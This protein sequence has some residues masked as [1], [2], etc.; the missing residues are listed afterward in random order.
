MRMP[1][2]KIVLFLGSGRSS[3][4]V[5]HALTS[6]FPIATTVVEAPIPPGEFLRR[7]VKR[8][9]VTTVAG[10]I[11]F[12]AAIVPWLE[13]LSAK[14]VRSILAANGLRDD[15]VGE[16][17]TRVRNVNEPEVVQLLR[18]IRPSV[19]VVNGTRI[20]RK[21]V[22]EATDAV[23]FNLH[24]GITPLYRGVHGGYWALADGKPEHCGVTVHVIDE[25][26]DTGS[27]VR[28]SI[29]EPTPR[30]NF[31]TYP[32]LQLAA[33][34][35]LLIDAVLASLEETLEELPAPEGPSRLWSHPTAWGYLWRRL[36]HGIR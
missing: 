30:D 32:Y 34:I 3:R 16:D 5:Y 19:I 21:P 17:V 1:R 36:R 2:S 31:A 14:R 6:R 27:I 33:G 8:L 18:E 28:Q 10:Q 9:G 29:I 23:I 11:A 35:P 15:P 13:K 7:R 4:I 12:R 26:L 24:A 20:L 25:G 22:L